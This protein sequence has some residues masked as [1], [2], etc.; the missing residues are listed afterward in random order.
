[1]PPTQQSGEDLVWYSYRKYRALC[2]HLFSVHCRKDAL[3]YRRMVA[4]EARIKARQ[5]RRSKKAA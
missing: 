3:T 2:E 1:V 5:E 4:E